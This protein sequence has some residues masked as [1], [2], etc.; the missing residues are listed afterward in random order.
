MARTTPLEKTRNIGIMAHIDAGKTTTTERILYYTGVNYK[1]GEVHDG[2]ATMDWMQQEQERGITI[3][4]AA[5]TCEWDGHRINII[6]TPGHVDFTIEVERSLRVLDGAV[7]VFCGVGGVEPQS[8][9]VWRQADKYRVPR[10]AFVNK[11]DR[12]GADFGNV[13]EM[14]T[15]RLGA[16]ALPIQLPIGA[17]EDFEGVVDV[18][19]G[20]A[21]YW[22][23]ESLGAKFREEEIPEAMRAQCAEARERVV[24]AAADFDDELMRRY[25]DGEE[26][27]AEELKSALRT[28]TVAQEVVPVLCGSAFKNKGVQPLLDSVI[29]FLPS[30]L[31]VPPIQGVRPKDGEVVT[32][33]ADDEEPFAALAF[34]LMADKHA[35][36][37][38]YLR[39]YSG[40]AKSG[41][42]LLNAAHGT[43]QRIGRF[44]QMHANKRQDVEEAFAG[45]IVAV[46]GLKN[47]STGDTLS[48]IDAPIVLETLQAPDPVISIAIEPKTTA[49]MDKLGQSLDR[50][51]LED[52]SFRVTTDPETGQTIISG[53]GELHLEIITDRLLRDFSVAAN[54]G[55]PQVSYKETI[56]KSV[57]VQGR[58]DKQAGG[59]GEFGVVRL[60]LG[61]GERGSGFSFEN[62]VKD[63]EIPS[64]F[65]PAIESGCEESVESGMLGGFRVADVKVRLMGGEFHDEYSSERSFKIASAMAMGEGLRIA[66]PVLLEPVMSVEVVTPDEFRGAIQGDLNS[67]RGQITGIE[68]RGNAQVISAEVPLAEMFGYVSSLRSMTQGRAS[69]TMQFS[70]Y[71]Q[72]PDSVVDRIV[73]R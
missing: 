31:D 30:P 29:D 3:T 1:I 71:D 28:G 68:M 65:I 10:I 20:K 55:K 5:T 48:A 16:N 42:T 72:A 57:K 69:Y 14:M 53:M 13:V 61:P 17:E 25:L 73:A 59:T 21:L 33:K 50:L 11:M 58:Y 46:V 37:L 64:E 60:E 4:A 70:H 63:G 62:G 12:V 27:T 41:N 19:K 36:H 35:G 24:E 43:K 56:T 18:V 45:D 2:A 66:D 67:R 38:T 8:E 9:T 34:K 40:H 49:D 23:D 54:V 7:A 6:D 22:D 39:V 47:V 15:D 32:R 44:L 52:P 51:A 26:I